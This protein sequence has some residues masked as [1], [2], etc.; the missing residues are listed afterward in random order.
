FRTIAFS[1]HLL[2]PQFDARSAGAALRRLESAEDR[3][4][5]AS[6]NR[7][8]SAIRRVVLSTA[9]SGA[10]TRYWSSPID[11]PTVVVDPGATVMTFVE[12]E[13]GVVTVD[14]ATVVVT[15]PGG[16]LPTTLAL[17]PVIEICCAS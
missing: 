9:R 11:V 13:P 10:A 7:P 16:P 12:V 3:L 8:W 15:T 5:R 2:L 4:V 17:L 14:V 1:P 6:P